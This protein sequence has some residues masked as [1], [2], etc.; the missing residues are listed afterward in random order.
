MKRKRITSIIFGIIVVI[1]AQK[2]AKIMPFETISM[3]INMDLINLVV[4]NEMDLAPKR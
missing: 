2:N 4:L 1:I 3:G